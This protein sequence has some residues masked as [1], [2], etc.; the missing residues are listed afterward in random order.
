[1]IRMEDA[2]AVEPGSGV[3]LSQGVWRKVK[4]VVMDPT[5]S[6]HLEETGVIKLRD[7]SLQ[8]NL[9]RVLKVISF[10]SRKTFVCQTVKFVNIALGIKSIA[11]RRAETDAM[12]WI[13][14]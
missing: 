2:I 10:V 1:M 8:T 14:S 6:A 5:V 11:D 3:N 7:A 4:V 12:E 9:A 13:I